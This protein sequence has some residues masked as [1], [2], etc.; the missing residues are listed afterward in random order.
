MKAL[1]ELAMGEDGSTEVQKSVVKP[2][3]Q[4]REAV[5]EKKR[6]TA[7]S[8]SAK[9]KSFKFKD[10]PFNFNG[11]SRYLGLTQKCESPK[12]V[13]YSRSRDGRS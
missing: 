8:A 2:A 1:A 9:P 5:V 13:Y 11:K 7:V 12:V 3:K 10:I 4:C 6:A